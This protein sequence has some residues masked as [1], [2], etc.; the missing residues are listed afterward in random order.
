MA[1]KRPS[2][3]SDAQFALFIEQMKGI[4]EG[5]AGSEFDHAV[6][7]LIGTGKVDL[8]S[9]GSEDTGLQE[10][11]L[12]EA[13]LE[14]AGAE[15]RS[16][17]AAS[18]SPLARTLSDLPEPPDFD[19]IEAAARETGASRAPL[20]VLIGK[21]VLGSANNESLLIYILMVLLQTDEPSA[22][23]V[24]STLN[25]TRAR[26]DL[27]SRL[28]R[29]RISDRETRDALDEVV[30]HF[31][32]ANRIR[33]E[34]LHAMYTVDGKGVIT[35][36]QTMR[37]IM[38]GGRTSFGE[39]TPIDRKRLDGMGKACR[40]LIN[41][42]RKIWELLPRLQEAIANTNAKDAAAAR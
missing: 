33:N 35:H 6:R 28:A 17:E 25:T 12:Q 26:L 41:L 10:A 16:A 4:L 2:A 18:P 40:D 9:A 29:V 36:T 32:D 24:F 31:N 5:G 11:G 38:K 8:P 7:R 21:L 13:G 42:N 15:E 30:K 3:H 39:Q 19:A 27:V 22:A 1:R 20:M 14:E 34:F 37:L 23:I